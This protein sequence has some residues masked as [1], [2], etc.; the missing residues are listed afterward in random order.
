MLRFHEKP[1]AEMGWINGGFFVLDPRVIDYIEADETVWER[2][3]LERLAADGQLMAYRH[4][5]FWKATGGATRVEHAEPQ[6]SQPYRA[7]SRRVKY[8]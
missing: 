6:L 8:R 5:G 4:S 1:D 7:S 3:P 2:Q